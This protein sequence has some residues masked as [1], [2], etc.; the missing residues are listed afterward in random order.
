MLI[1]L[2]ITMSFVNFN[3]LGTKGTKM[4][5]YTTWHTID[6]LDDGRPDLNYVDEKKN[7]RMHKNMVMFLSQRSLLT[8][9]E[10]ARTLTLNDKRYKHPDLRPG[11]PCMGGNAAGDDGG[12]VH[13]RFDG[14]V[15]YT[16]T[17]DRYAEDGEEQLPFIDYEMT[18]EEFN[19]AFD[20][21]IAAVRKW[22]QDRGGV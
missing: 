17:F 20:P 2:A 16:T 19:S 5:G 6:I 12:W 10:A 8:D 9:I 3:S 21:W 13:F 7:S 15:I 18:L 22:Q 1:V 11:D 4:N 14:M